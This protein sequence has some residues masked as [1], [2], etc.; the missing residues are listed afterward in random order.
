MANTIPI[1]KWL[2][3]MKSEYLSEF[4]PEGGASVK[5]AVV[6]PEV[7]ELVIQRAAEEFS[8]D[9]YVVIRL[10]AAKMG[11]HMPQDIFWSIAEEVDWRL[12]A[13]RVVLHLAAEQHYRTEGIDATAGSIFQAIAN[14]NNLGDDITPIVASVRPEIVARVFH[15]KDLAREFRVAMYHLTEQESRDS[16]S[17]GPLL[18]WLRGFNRRVGNMQSFGIYTGINRATARYFIEST[19]RWVK[20]AGYAGTVLLFDNSRVLLARNPKDGRRFY[21]GS[22]TMDHYE[23]LREF[24]DATDRLSNVLIIVVTTPEF[25]ESRGGGTRGYFIYPALESRVMDDV[26]DRNQANPVGS[27]AHLTV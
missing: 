2:A 3:T 14:K 9:D 16:Y 4:I 13:R 21:T 5:F 1:E 25:A 17:G 18:D 20:S 7:K 8:S 15:N 6:P 27:L 23:V 22:M 19:F 12:L 26:R 24:M 11:A 10:D